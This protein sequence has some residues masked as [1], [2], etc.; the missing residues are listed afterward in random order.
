MKYILCILCLLVLPFSVLANSEE[1]GK[2][3]SWKQTLEDQKK[4]FEG[5]LGLW[6]LR[7]CNTA[8]VSAGRSPV[9]G[10][11]HVV[12][13]QDPTNVGAWRDPMTKGDAEDNFIEAKSQ[14]ERLEDAIK[15]TEKELSETNKKI[16]ELE[17]VEAGGG[18]GGGG[19]S[20]GGGGGGGY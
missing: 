18:E 7:I 14:V 12:P 3:K 20:G 9:G 17:R 10:F 8:L 13:G 4:Q 11:T 5:E 1:I 15:M 16:N 2:L 6:K 19:S